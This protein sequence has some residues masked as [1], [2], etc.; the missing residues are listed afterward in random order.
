[1]NQKYSQTQWTVLKLGKGANCSLQKLSL[2]KISHLHGKRYCRHSQH[3]P[4]FS[5]IL[6]SYTF[7]NYKSFAPP[8]E[9]QNL[10]NPWQFEG[11]IPEY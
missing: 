6:E 11:I 8:A 9:A 2:E 7:D 5:K 1:M 10:R 3:F 4:R